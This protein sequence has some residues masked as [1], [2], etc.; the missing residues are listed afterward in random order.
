MRAIQRWSG[1]TACLA[2]S[3]AL[4]LILAGTVEAQR[5]GDAWRLERGGPQGPGNTAAEF[6]LS[7]DSDGDGLI[8][9]AEFL[10]AYEAMF[11]FMDVSGDGKIDP[12]EIR[13]DLAAIYNKSALWARQTI[14]RY[15]AD[16][17]GRLSAREAPF[18]KMAF[19]RADANKDGFV[20]RRELTEL[21]FN[22]SLLDEGLRAQNPDKI[23]QAFLK[24]CDANKDGKISV[25]EF[26]W[27][28][29]LFKRYDRDRNGSL[30]RDE[31]ARI[32]P[33]GPTPGSRARDLLRQRDL[34]KDG[35]LSASEFGETAERF[36]SADLNAD[37]SLSLEELTKLMASRI[38]APKRISRE[39][40]LEMLPKVRRPEGRKP[41]KAAPRPKVKE[42]RQPVKALEPNA[43]LV[44]PLRKE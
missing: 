17:D 5:A 19:E 43:P 29:L 14:E 10:K 24:R 30:E 3:A 2:V 38:K 13:R 21:R 42:G 39:K 6:I 37:G 1:R 44:G 32:P 40:R 18:W 16:E 33:L 20:E 23:V 26:G 15:D 31:I 8:S 4:T 22:L 12:S 9:K 25:D 11:E 7:F 34:N 41:Q 36:H 28:E 27:G 35:R